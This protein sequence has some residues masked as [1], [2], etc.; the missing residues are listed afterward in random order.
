MAA[1]DY[2]MR[3]E[4]LIS[5][6]WFANN[7]LSNV[8]YVRVQRFVTRET[9]RNPHWRPKLLSALWY[10]RIAN[11]SAERREFAPIATVCGSP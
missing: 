9:D 4:R 2:G 8:F 11:G 1:R 6:S 10:S 7:V 3:C 5:N